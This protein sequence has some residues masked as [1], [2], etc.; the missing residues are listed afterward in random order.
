MTA[1]ED[2]AMFGTS[3]YDRARLLTLTAAESAQ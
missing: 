3:A 1:E 2:R